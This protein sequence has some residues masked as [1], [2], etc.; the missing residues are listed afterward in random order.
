MKNPFNTLFGRLAILTVSLIVAI[1]VTSLLLVDRE[2][3]RI[4]AEHM[5][6]GL[7]IAV[8]AK[9]DNAT[10]ASHVAAMLGMQ[11]VPVADAIRE[12]CPASCTGTHGPLEHDLL[13]TMPAGSVVSFDGATGS[14]WV[15][16]GN[17]PYWIYMRHSNLPASRFIG[18]SLVTLALAIMVALLAAWQFQQPLHRLAEAAREFRIG[19]RAAPVPEKG[20]AEMR[21]L[22]GDFN[23]MMSELAQSEQERAVMLAGVAHDLRAPITRMQVRADMLPDAANR[24]GFLQDAASLSRIVTQFLDYARDTADPSPRVSVDAHCRRHY[25]DGIGDDSLV[26]LDL[27]AGDGFTLPL[28]ELDRILSN[29]IENAMNYGE[30]PVEISTAGTHGRYTL[31]VR[32]HGPGIPQDQLERAL[33]PFVR[34]D[35]ARGGDAHCGLGLAIVRRL[36][37]HNGGR[38]DCDN[39]S[40]GGFR[41]TLT[42]ENG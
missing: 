5:L 33:Q 32:D 30:P 41:V 18:S 4:D 2:R 6:S 23:Q 3:G 9:R 40:D 39:A 36:T 16:Y 10:V 31:T 27:R 25:G 34:L 17:A 38:F 19:R 42:F 24:A 20:P 35:A 11:F 15:R 22:I 29:V 21:A 14:M 26:K 8:E 1:H 28:V 37:R 12:G 13:Q 7:R